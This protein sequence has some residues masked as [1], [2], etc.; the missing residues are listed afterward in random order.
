MKQRFNFLVGSMAILT[1]FLDQVSKSFASETTVNM[2]IAFGLLADNFFSVRIASLFF[3]VIAS[4]V[5]WQF[6]SKWQK[7]PI[8]L[9]MFAGGVFGNL[10]D[11]LIY[12]GV[13]D[14]L[15]LPF[16]NLTNNLADWFIFISLSWLCLTL[17]SE[18]RGVR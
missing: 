8:A 3:L 13:R 2:G 5:I 7:I 16:M 11:R 1:L 17:L 15:T 10:L 9:G 14:W 6:W 4:L 18:R 12:G